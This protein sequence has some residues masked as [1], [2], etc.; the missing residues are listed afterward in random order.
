LPC[1]PQGINDR[2]MSLRLPLL[3]DQF[4]TIMSAYAPTMTCSDAVKVKF[5][6]DLHALPA[7]VLKAEKLIVLGDFNAHVG[8]DRASWIGVLVPHGLGSCNDN[9]LFLLRTFEFSKQITQKPE[10]LHAPDNNATMETRW[11]PLRNGI[12]S[13]TLEVLGRARRQHQ[14]LFDDNDANISNLLAEKNRLHKAYMDLRTD[15]T[16]A[17]FFRCRC[18]VQQRL[19]EMQDAWMIRKAEEIQEYAD[20][21]EINNFFTVIYSRLPNS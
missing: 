7:T 19:R 2:L 20:R 13:T 12:Q 18:L 16:K 11:C 3:G 14:D 15:A 5:Y 8:T 21:N 4:A 10:N 6:E 17:A 1:L 9:G